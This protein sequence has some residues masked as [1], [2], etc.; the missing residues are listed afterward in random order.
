MSIYHE[1]E[2]QMNAAL[3]AHD[4]GRKSAMRM[5]RARMKQ[6][7]IDNRV[8]GE[9]PDAEALQVIAT[10]VRQL[11]KAIPEFE[12][13]GEAAR[14]KVEELRA[15]IAILQPFLPALLDEAATRAIV[16]RAVEASGR[17]PIQKAG[18]VIGM[19]MKEHK[20]E[21]DAALVKRLVEEALSG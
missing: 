3:K 9:L 11:Q 6:Y 21:V 4:E 14:G 8:A 2:E 5:V 19:V 15:E 10:Y 16:L 17:P 7:A 18:M 20:G 13:G 1:V 12:K